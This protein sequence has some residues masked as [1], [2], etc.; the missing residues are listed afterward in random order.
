MS[1]NKAQHNLTNNTLTPQPPTPRNPSLSYNERYGSP[2]VN[3]IGRTYKLSSVNGCGYS[4][5][6]TTTTPPTTTTGGNA[7][8]KGQ[9]AMP[10]K[11]YPSVGS[12]MF[13]RARCTYSNDAGGGKSWYSSSQHIH[14]KKINAIGKSSRG[15]KY[16]SSGQK[17]PI[18]LAFS[19]KNTNDVKR[20]LGRTRSG[21]TVAPA[22]KGLFGLP[23]RPVGG[24]A[25]NKKQGLP[26]CC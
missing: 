3:G 2:L 4:Y 20:A 11:F 8:I 26:G 13:S 25:G 6:D 14:L 16:N 12:S 7:I 21:G 17:E 10:E 22:K 5:T 19:S 18:P 24:R 9:G 15:F 1:I 23:N